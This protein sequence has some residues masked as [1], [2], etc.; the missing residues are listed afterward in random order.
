[1]DVNMM[2]GLMENIKNIS[3]GTSKLM[4]CLRVLLLEESRKEVNL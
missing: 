3:Q 4:K 1:M 2:F